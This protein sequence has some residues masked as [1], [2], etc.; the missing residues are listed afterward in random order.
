[1]V[2]LQPECES[3]GDDGCDDELTVEDQIEILSPYMCEQCQL[4]LVYG[5]FCYG[6]LPLLIEEIEEESGECV[7]CHKDC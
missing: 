6:C 4:R 2:I 3:D 7:I 1:M 5:E